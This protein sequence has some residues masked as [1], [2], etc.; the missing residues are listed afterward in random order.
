LSS[1]RLALKR[2]CLFPLKG[3]QLI[4]VYHRVGEGQTAL[5]PNGLSRIELEDLIIA[6]Q[7]LGFRFCSLS[8]AYA[9]AGKGT[10]RTISLSSD[11]GFACNYDVVLP[12]LQKHRIPL[13]LFVIG[14]CLDNR[15]LAWN[16]KLIQIRQNSDEAELRERVRTLQS[17]YRLRLTDDLSRQLFSVP[18]Q[19]KDDLADELWQSFCSES[20]TDFLKR[21]QPFLTGAQMQKLESCGAEFALH[22]HSHA[23]FSRLSYAQMSS[24]IEQNQIALAQF[25]LRPAPFFGF[26]YGR[27]CQGDLIPKLCR[28]TGLLACLGFRYRIDDN[29]RQNQLWQRSHLEHSDAL[30]LE[31]L[32]WRPL[33]RCVKPQN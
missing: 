5:Y 2:L 9:R 31:Q 29:R 15:A 12:L 24:E 30:S 19:L 18:D 20:Q 26:P 33:L 22:S 16:H 6:F 3:S 21:T 28:D 32:L 23:D 7:E 10:E 17:R 27:Q 13:T 11:D 4:L 8:E 1:F 25:N 14:K